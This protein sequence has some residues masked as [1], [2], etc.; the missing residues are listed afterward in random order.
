M[1]GIGGCG[2][3]ASDSQAVAPTFRARRELSRADRGQPQ[4]CASTKDGPTAPMN[5]AKFSNPFSKLFYRVLLGTR[6]VRFSP[7]CDALGSHCDEAV[8]RIYVI[9]LD[10]QDNRWRQMRRELASI[11]DLGGSP[12]TNIARRFSAV[13]ARY[14]IDQPDDEVQHEYSLADQLFVDPHPLPDGGRDTRS[15]RIEMSRQEAAVARSHV[16]VWKLIAG[17]SPLYTLVLEDDG[18][19]RRW[20]AKAFDRAWAELEHAHGNPPF[21]LLY[22]AYGEARAG[23]EMAPVSRELL[24]PSR[25]VW[26]LSGYVLS[27][28]GA[29][30]L[31]DLL[32]VRGPVDLWIN[33]QFENLDVLAV[34]RPVIQQRLD[35]PSSN[36]YSVLPILS[37]I[38]VLTREKPSTISVKPVPAPVFAFGKHGTGLTALATALSMLAYRCCSDVAALPDREH[39]ALFRNQRARVFDAYVNVGSLKLHDLIELA[40]VYPRGQFIVTTDDEQLLG[41]TAVDL[42]QAVTTGN[43]RIAGNLHG[44]PENSSRILVLPAQH[45]DKWQL[46]CGFLGCEYPSNQYPECTD[47]G[48]RAL[49]G[50]SDEARLLRLPEAI[51]L[52]WDSSPW[53]ADRSEWPGLA[54]EGSGF[55]SHPQPNICGIS[56]R[57]ESFNGAT[58]TLRDDTF[59]SNLALFSPANFEVVD[60]GARLTLRKEH[61][62]VRE[63]TSAALSSREGYRYGQFVAELRPAKVAGVI[64]GLFLHRNA[65]RQEI[66]IEF[67][68]NDTTKL[69]VNVYYNPGYEG[70]R[71]EYGYRGTPELIE[72]GFDAAEDF[73]R[74]EIEWTP[75]SIRWRVDGR[76]VC[77][78]VQWNPTLIPHLPMHFHV[79]LWHSRSTALAGKLARA[80]LPAHAELRRVE[81]HA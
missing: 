35:C 71:L 49:A 17:G 22:L 12:L 64:T 65:P 24:R 13:D 81:V 73:H 36:S 69:L 44:L 39:Q 57:F 46:L 9:N 52:K 77:Q 47:Q 7:V 42:S 45:H 66:D 75:T 79:N 58:W 60:S 48:Q 14:C 23:A 68:G 54:L 34:R 27:R 30:R 32:P 41:P 55:E 37:K 70:A 5:D 59:P 74:Y 38:G 50:A 62:V 56:E 33:H 11:R 63:Y 25:G 10:R 21:D 43:G 1:H 2:S 78:R 29:Q 51:R 72:L 80:N 3:R 20:F 8:Q 31:L 19:F 61:A 15:L 26:Q 53:I 28:R 16:A 76:L 4:I 18:Y 67:L 40:N 6:H